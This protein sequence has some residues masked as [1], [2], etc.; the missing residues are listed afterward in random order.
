MRVGS[1]EVSLGVVVGEVVLSVEGW[2]SLVMRR[3]IS[4]CLLEMVM[5]VTVAEQFLAR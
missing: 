4:T 2:Y 1:A 3:A 5:P